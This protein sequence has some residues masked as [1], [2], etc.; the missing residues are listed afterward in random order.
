MR[1]YECPSCGAAIPFASRAAVFAVCPHCRSMVVRTDVKLE[2]IGTMAELP[3]DLSPLQVGTQGGWRGRAFTLLGRLRLAWE[4]GSWTEWYA[5]F[6]DGQRGWLAETQGFFTLSWQNQTDALPQRI[7]GLSAGQTIDFARRRWR[8]VDGKQVTCLGGEGELPF[9]ARPGTTRYSLDLAGPAGEFGTLE[10]ADGQISFYEGS[11]TRFLDLGLTHL[12]P[13]PG[14]SENAQE[15]TRRQSRTLSCPSCAAP[16]ELRAPGQ[17]MSVV[18]GSCRT[19]LDSSQPDIQV[20]QRA[21]AVQEELTPVLSLGQRGK[22][23]DQVYEVIGLVVREDN[24]ARWSEYL[25]FNPWHGFL[26]LVTYQGHWSL[27]YRLLTPPQSLGTRNLLY[28]GNN[29][30]LF[31]QGETKVRSVL[32]EFYWRVS[33]GEISTVS[34]FVAGPRIISKESYPELSEETWSAGEYRTP[35]EIAEAFSLSPQVLPRPSGPYLNEPNP[36]ETKWQRV[37]RWAALALVAVFA[38]Q[39]FFLATQ[40]ANVVFTGDY[41]HRTGGP[42]QAEITTPSFE[43][44]AISQPVFVEASAPVSNSWIDLDFELVNAVTG[45]TRPVQ[46]EVSFYSGTDSDG[47][48]SEGSRK[49]EADLAAVPKGTYFLRIASA[50]DAALR[51]LP[52]SVRVRTGGVFW[53]NFIAAVLAILLYPAWVLWRR[54]AFEHRRWAESD[55]STFASGSN[56][57]DD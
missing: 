28:K 9:I 14:W 20:I 27:V 18:C 6:G 42:E 44:P 49:R 2:A 26:W 7:R 51:E 13:V 40:S 43:L 8:V 41:V 55:F 10:D 21:Q 11:Y 30:S 33:R 53:S 56:D 50:T 17:S 52:F 46:V 19:V 23:F 25:L 29:Y 45:E 38:I 31:A 16:V 5:E 34:D 48:W 15:P 22:F 57:D 37:R 35:G 39:L 54:H 36:Y 12:R 24:F 3:P 1:N 4:Q 47:A 32:G